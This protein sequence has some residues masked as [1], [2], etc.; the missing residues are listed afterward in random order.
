MNA[1]FGTSGRTSK[2][3][4]FTK[5]YVHNENRAHWRSQLGG[6]VGTPASADCFTNTRL[7]GPGLEEGLDDRGLSDSTTAGSAPGGELPSSSQEEEM[8]LGGGGGRREGFPAASQEEG[9]ELFSSFPGGGGEEGEQ[10][11]AK[12]PP[13]HTAELV[14]QLDDRGLSAARSRQSPDPWS[15]PKS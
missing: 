6:P 11:A 10:V 9:R 7:D 4:K 13:T 12:R 8:E 5:R 2:S 14:E 1:Y 15:G 3:T